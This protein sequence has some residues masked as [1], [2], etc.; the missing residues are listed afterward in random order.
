MISGDKNALVVLPVAILYLCLSH[1]VMKRLRDKHSDQ[2]V[3]LGSPGFMKLPA[4]V[5]TS[6]SIYCLVKS[7]HNK[8][9]DPV[10]NALI[11]ATRVLFLMLLAGLV[12][13]FV[14]PQT[15]SQSLG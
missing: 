6:F 4:G 12:W 2:W 9:G 10:L 15:F 8:R 13:I 5:A 3:A 14:H 11:Y 1:A 7:D